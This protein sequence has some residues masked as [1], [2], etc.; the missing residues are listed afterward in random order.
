MYAYSLNI[1]DINRH[2]T[3]S[4]DQKILVNPEG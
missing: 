4:Y 3:V 1:Y 2:R